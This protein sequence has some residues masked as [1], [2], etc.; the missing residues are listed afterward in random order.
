M[1]ILFDPGAPD[2]L[3]AVLEGRKLFQNWRIVG[4]YQDESAAG[5]DF[6]QDGFLLLFRERPEHGAGDNEYF[7]VGVVLEQSLQAGLEVR[8]CRY[9]VVVRD[10]CGAAAG[11]Q[12]G[13]V[14]VEVHPLGQFNDPALVDAALEDDSFYLACVIWPGPFNVGGLHFH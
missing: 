8:I 7:P 9:A 11:R 10:V 6:F 13:S 3:P 4:V 14:K 2:S 5:L 1:V 12:I